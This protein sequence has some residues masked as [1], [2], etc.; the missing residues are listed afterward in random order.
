MLLN[1]TRRRLT[2]AADRVIVLFDRGEELA[3][4]SGVGSQWDSFLCFEMLQDDVRLAQ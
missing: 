4:D 1:V 3:L 2:T